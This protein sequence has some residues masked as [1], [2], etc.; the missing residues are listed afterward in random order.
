MNFSTPLALPRTRLL[1]SDAGSSTALSSDEES[2]T[3]SSPPS[4]KNS[5]ASD[6]TDPQSMIS[7]LLADAETPSETPQLPPLTEMEDMMRTP[8]RSRTSSPEPSLEPSPEESSPEAPTKA[9]VKKRKSF[10]F[11]FKIKLCEM[12]NEENNVPAV[13]R[14]NGVHERVLRR[15]RKQWLMGKLVAPKKKDLKK[16]RQS[17]A[18][19]KPLLSAKRENE[20]YEWVIDLRLNKHVVTRAMLK[21]VATNFA[22][23]DGLVNFVASDRWVKNFMIRHKLSMRASST[24][25]RLSDEQLV[26]RIHA[27]HKFMDSLDWRGFRDLDVI[28]MD[29]T[30]VYL[31]NK[32]SMT[33]EK[34]GKK[35]VII[36]S[37]GYESMR[38]TC[39]LAIDR[40]GEKLPP[41]LIAKGKDDK[42]PEVHSGVQVIFSK[43]A[44]MN[45]GAVRK[46]LTLN[47]P[48]RLRNLRGSAKTR[49]ALLVWDAAP[50][51]RAANVQWGMDRT[52]HIKQAMIPAGTTSYLQSLDVCINRPFKHHLRQS[53]DEYLLHPQARNA[54][55]N[56][57]KPD[58]PTVCSWISSAWAAITKEQV[59]KALVKGYISKERSWDQTFVVK[60][61]GFGPALRAYER[62]E[63]ARLS[64]QDA[65]PP[66][67]DLIANED[68]V[69]SESELA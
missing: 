9:E 56:L 57:V 44:W 10:T 6:D 30:A 42:F 40:R 60:N 59:L 4:R 69:D 2:K 55:G 27:F 1:S 20:I 66:L 39:A 16:M 23:H 36:P 49:D 8:Q 22:Q 3:L 62:Q 7:A 48:V 31:G 41:T 21:K 61:M 52:R 13:A 43:K 15:W 64:G 46:W 45:E 29:E 47:V 11:D 54:R 58:L 50:S 51:H 38:Y 35:K 26:E 65:P 18:G 67:A 28:A 19:R 34:K 24:Q 37:T 17:G 5:G 12:V 68:D 32:Q 63:N 53:I 25:S 33:I 14:A